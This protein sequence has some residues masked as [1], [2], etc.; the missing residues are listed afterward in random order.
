VCSSVEGP[1]VSR[2]RLQMLLEKETDVTRR[3]R[4]QAALDA[5]KK[6]APGK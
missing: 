1:E 2:F 4:I 5:L 3:G 6:I